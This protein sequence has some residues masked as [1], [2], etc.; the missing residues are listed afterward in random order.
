MKISRTLGVLF[1]CFLYV[2]KLSA[3]NL[4]IGQWR[5]HLPYT[6]GQ[7]VA[8]AGNKIYCAAEDA[9]FS[10]NKEDNSIATYSK[11]NGLSDIGTSV[12]RYNA[13][14]SVLLIGYENANIDL[15][16]G[17]EII[18]ISDIK[19]KNILGSKSINDVTFI[20]KYAYLSCGF[21]I[22]V[23]DLERRE[24]KDTYYIEP[25]GGNMNV[26]GIAF[27]GTDLFAASDSG[28]YRININNPSINFY[29]AWTNILEKESGYQYNQILYF[30][31]KIFINVHNVSN[32]HLKVFENNVWTTPGISVYDTRRLR[33]AND[34]LVLTASYDVKVYDTNLQSVISV[35][36]STYP[37][38]I[39]DAYLD[40]GGVLW[41]ADNNKGL[42][43]IN[44]FTPEFIVPDG[45]KSKLSADLQIVN[46]QLWVG[47]ATRGRK[48]SSS[49]SGEGF[50]TFVGDKW[51]TY[52][53]SN[54]TSPI[55]SMDTLYDFMSVAIDNRNTN[56]VF[57][58]THGTGI[59]EMENGVVK[60]Y[61][62]EANSTLQSALGNPGSCETGG[63][64]FDKDYNLWVANS[65]VAAPLLERKNDGTWQSFTF[66]GGVPSNPSTGEMI[67]D[68]YGQKW[69]DFNEQGILVYD[70]TGTIGNT[71]YKFLTTDEGK[72]HLPSNDVRSI[73]ED[74]DGQV[75]IGTA[76][77]VAVFYSPASIL[78]DNTNF[79]A[80]QILLLQD[81]SYQYLLA[82]E[83][84]TSIA[85]DGANYKWIGTENSGVFY[86]SP[87]GTRQ[88]AHFTAEDSPLLSNNISCIAINQK[89]G[90]VFIGTDRGIISIRGFA[91]EGD[92]VCKDTYVFPNPVYHDY[93]GA[94]TIKGLITNSN[95][96]ITDVSGT[97]V[98][99]T[100][101]LGGQA[102]WDGKNFKGE[103]A[104]TGV[105][106]VFCSDS[107]GKNSC[108]TKL[109]LIN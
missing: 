28:I 32:D 55:V 7:S 105:Y 12:I 65:S 36:Q 88:I 46:D 77:G 53:R 89:S 45:P 37:C 30:N 43:K 21:G 102:F 14:Y 64:L 10:Y 15:V 5:V 104:H 80:Q 90:E 75:W 67:I 63:V 22:V 33:V 17:N 109:L 92:E 57:L 59:L 78:S 24:I 8:V 49:Y 25:N 52:N 54:L 44:N 29:S 19:R 85:V 82:T 73:A 56:H 11:I 108:M 50:S 40:E 81:G 96:K 3:Q 95:V 99:E 72:G 41:I 93:A 9:L 2:S 91:T 87:D 106:L 69:V 34:K 101:S 98:Y 74:K 1:F 38:L 31:N 51:T 62:N 35:G 103:K 20:G 27:D 107:E 48:W 6:K 47:H 84:V 39:K 26:F 83:V 13:Q 60:N 70:E 61:Y 86:M 18:N 76:A 16:Y 58:G 94:I 97:L 4:A 71:K 42:V 66:P 23:V 100:T 79:D 68:S